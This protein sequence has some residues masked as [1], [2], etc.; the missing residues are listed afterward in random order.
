MRPLPVSLASWNDR[1]VDEQRVLDVQIGD[2]VLE[3]LIGLEGWTSHC[4]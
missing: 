1:I 2:V 4:T 3:L